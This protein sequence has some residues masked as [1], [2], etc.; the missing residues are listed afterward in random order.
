MKWLP[1]SLFVAAVSFFIAAVFADAAGA[2]IV[3]GC[4]LSVLAV[5]MRKRAQT[6]AGSRKSG[7][8]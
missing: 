4:A 7:I 5:M 3:I 1:A 8:E 6:T 2:F